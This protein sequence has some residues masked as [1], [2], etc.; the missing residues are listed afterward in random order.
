MPACL[1]HSASL[2]TAVQVDAVEPMPNEPAAATAEPSHGAQLETGRVECLAVPANPAEAARPSDLPR[3]ELL[4]RSL[5]APP[6]LIEKPQIPKA[7]ARL[8]LI[9][10]LGLGLIAATVAFRVASSVH[11]CKQES[12]LDCAAQCNQKSAASCVNLGLSYATGTGVAKDAAR[13][14]ALYQQGCDGG[15][16]S[17]ARPNPERTITARPV[18]VISLHW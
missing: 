17:A 10:S 4:D 6:V 9:A 7:T 2:Q 8:W 11:V 14:A 18:R 5:T 12:P 3:Q 15:D 13:A 1:A 16:A